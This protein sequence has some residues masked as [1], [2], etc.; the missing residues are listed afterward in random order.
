MSKLNR[1]DFVKLTG[2]VALAS[3]V[4]G[5][6]HVARAAG[7]QVVVVGGG[8]GGATAAKYIRMADPTVEVTLIEPLERYHTCF[9][10]NE[11]LAGERDLDS[12]AFGYDGLK[13]HGVTVVHDLVVG[14][15]PAAKK[16]TTKGG[17]TFPYDRAIVAPGI[18]FKWEAIAGYGPEVAES[19]PHAWK[20]GPQTA[21]LRKQLEAMPDGGKVVIVAPPDPF[22]CPPGPY[23]R[24]SLIANYLKHHKPKS[25]V[26]IL[27]AKD[28]F[29]KQGL[30]QAGWKKMYGFGTDSSL[31]EWVSGAAGGKVESIDPKAMTLQGAVESFQGDVINLIPPQ[32]AGKIAFEADLVDGDWCPINKQTFES[33]KHPGIHVLG[34]ATAAPKMPKSGYSANSQAK[35]CAAAVVDLLNGRE[36]GVPSYVN[37]CYSIVGDDYGISVAA[38]YRLSADG[39]EISP[40]EGAGGLTPADASPENLKREVQYAHSWFANITN[41]T[42]G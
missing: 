7:K 8:I 16:V 41:D 12:L 23:E 21:I 35:V 6:P 34:D 13:K 2:G 32:K 37:T 24:A 11:V 14:I 10:S 4:T 15:D 28:K 9:M 29:A 27:D 19:V 22:R 18:D 1:R 42:F 26:L 36:P 20:A 25:K 5:F 17:Q 31:I 40:V 38:V 39:K 3:M 30:F 33:T